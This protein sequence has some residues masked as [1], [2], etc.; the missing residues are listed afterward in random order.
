MKSESQLLQAARERVLVFDG[1][2][3]T[4]VHNLELPLEDYDGHENCTDYLVFSCP[5]G[6]LC[7]N[8]VCNVLKEILLLH[9]TPNRLFRPT[10]RR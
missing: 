3:G 2:I 5:D 10:S 4:S 8:V 7:A 6:C 1:A 9:N